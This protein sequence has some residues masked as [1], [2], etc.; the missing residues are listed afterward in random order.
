VTELAVLENVSVIM[1][2]DKGTTAISNG[3]TIVRLQR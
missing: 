3:M 2:L 1:L